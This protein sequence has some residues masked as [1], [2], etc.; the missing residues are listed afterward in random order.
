MSYMNINLISG[1][2]GTTP[3]HLQY[4][5][6]GVIYEHKLDFR[7]NSAA[8]VPYMNTNLIFGATLEPLHSKSEATPEYLSCT[9]EPLQSTSYT[10]L[11]NTCHI[12]HIVSYMNTN[13]ISGATL[14]PLLSKS[15]ANPEHLTYTPHSVI[16]EHKLD[17]WSNFGATPNTFHTPHDVIYEHKLDLWSNSGAT[18]EQI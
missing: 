14:E 16:Y 2:T 15:K 4:T 8:M 17:F 9:L 3:K 18:H 1:T 7:R 10:P 13:L 6:H 11:Q 5:T 12:P